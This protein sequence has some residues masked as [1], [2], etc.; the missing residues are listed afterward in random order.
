MLEL[1][2]IKTL[3]RVK[4]AN[5]V[6]TKIKEAQINLKVSKHLE[7][8][9]GRPPWDTTKCQR[10]EHFLGLL[11][12]FTRSVGAPCESHIVRQNKSLSRKGQLGTPVRHKKRS[13]LKKEGR[14][15]KPPQVP[16]RTVWRP[17]DPITRAQLVKT[18]NVQVLQEFH[19]TLHKPRHFAALWVFNKISLQNQWMPDFMVRI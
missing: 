12:T 8:Q 6:L 15:R 14:M 3:N 10:N 16:A 19:S 9:L 7:G 4:S 17:R 18:T 2:N 5:Q 13:L 11:S 1:Q